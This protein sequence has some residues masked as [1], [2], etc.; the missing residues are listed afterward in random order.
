MRKYAATLFFTGMVLSGTAFSQDLNF[1]ILPLAINPAFTGMFDGRLRATGL[2]KKQLTAT[3]ANF[4]AYGASVDGRMLIKQSGYLAV[5]LGGL[6]GKLSN[7]SLDNSSGIASIAYHKIFTRAG[8]NVRKRMGELAAGIQ[9]GY[10]QRSLH[11]AIP[12]NNSLP[13]VYHTG[14]GATYFIVNAGLSFSQFVGQKFNYTIGISGNNLNLL[15][16]GTVNNEHPLLRVTPSATALFIASWR[17]GER[18]TLRPAVLH[19]INTD[20]YIAGNEFRYQT[21]KVAPSHVAFITAWYRSTK[22]I[23]VTPGYEFSRLRVALGF[24]YRL[25]PGST[26]GYAGFQVNARYIVPVKKGS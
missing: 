25:S 2:Y 11:L 13:L 21:S 26:H 15:N 1:N 8:K 23:T 16:D 19:I 10:I 12:N 9:A 6:Q 20:F 7:G 3:K 17:T 18:L 14:I 22:I 5:G 4:I 24:D